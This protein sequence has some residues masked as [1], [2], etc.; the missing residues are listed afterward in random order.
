MN[1]FCT[2]EILCN[3]SV[4]QWMWGAGG[5]TGAFRTFEILCSHVVFWKCKALEEPCKHVKHFTYYEILV[6]STNVRRCS[7]QLVKKHGSAIRWT[8]IRDKA[9]YRRTA[10]SPFAEPAIY[11]YIYICGYIYGYMAIYGHIWVYTAI[12]RHIL[13]YIYIYI[14]MRVFLEC[15][16]V[17]L[18]LQRWC[19]LT[20][21]R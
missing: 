6:F 15:P 18:H 4:C 5:T 20:S 21:R 8:R 14:Y 9:G 13:Q 11:I 17:F 19:S 7:R 12:C 3:H 10:V 16:F 2:F 1:T